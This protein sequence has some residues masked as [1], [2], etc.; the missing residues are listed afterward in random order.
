M[1]PRAQ[2][3]QVCRARRRAERRGSA[4]AESLPAVPAACPAAGHGRHG[5]HT[6]TPAHRH[7]PPSP[8]VPCP[9]WSP[10]AAGLASPRGLA[11]ARAAVPLRAPPLGRAGRRGAR[12]ESAGVA[13]PPAPQQRWR[14]ADR[15]THRTCPGARW[16]DSKVQPGTFHR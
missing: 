2:M 4:P 9:L 15:V 7:A 5:R 12:R 16:R 1:P 8:S 11:P 10:P 6:G 13:A 3:R 14:G